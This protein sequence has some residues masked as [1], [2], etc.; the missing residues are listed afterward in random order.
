MF[1]K[2]QEKIVRL[3]QIRLKERFGDIK[4]FKEIEDIF[5]LPAYPLPLTSQE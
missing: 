3:K 1:T 5:I 4:L 2:S